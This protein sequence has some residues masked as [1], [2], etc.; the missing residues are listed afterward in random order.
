MPY[1]PATL[2][3][4]PRADA[5]HESGHGSVLWRRCEVQRARIPSWLHSFALEA[6]WRVP[7]PCEYVLQAAAAGR[8]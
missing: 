1:K 7:E 6:S 4:A 2:T 8:G 5:D 3:W